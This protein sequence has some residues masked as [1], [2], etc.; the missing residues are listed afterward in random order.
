MRR[1]SNGM[2]RAFQARYPGSTQI[3]ARDLVES[4]QVGH[5]FGSP[6]TKAAT[7]QRSE[8]AP[9]GADFIFKT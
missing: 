4:A 3:S 7:M 9:A 6:T 1:W 5:S 8:K 2:T